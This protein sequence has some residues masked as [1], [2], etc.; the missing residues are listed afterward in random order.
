MEKQEASAMEK[1]E[2]SSS[3]STSEQLGVARKYLALWENNGLALAC[4]NQRKQVFRASESVR[5]GQN[6]RQSEKEGQ[7][8][9]KREKHTCIHARAYNKTSIVFFFAVAL[10]RLLVL[11]ALVCVCVCVCACV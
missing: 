2:A 7:R 9:R 3:S 8:E 4:E 11:S 5:E 1:Q 6:T 10:T